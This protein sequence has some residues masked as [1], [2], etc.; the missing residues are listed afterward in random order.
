M[1]FFWQHFLKSNR[2]SKQKQKLGILTLSIWYLLLFTKTSFH[3]I[4]LYFNFQYWT[5]NIFC[6]LSPVLHSHNITRWN[7]GSQ[8][9]SKQTWKASRASWVKGTSD[10]FKGLRWSPLS[11]FH[12]SVS[13]MGSCSKNDSKRC[14][15]ACMVKKEITQ[16]S[17]GKKAKKNKTSCF[18]WS[19]AVALVQ[20][21][22]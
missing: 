9:R 14:S 2:R 16:T 10:S 5:L 15:K 20:A 17:A 22:M 12:S 6:R 19:K 7:N 1:H 18:F 21:Y 3:Y 8:W 11:W 13:G 4:E